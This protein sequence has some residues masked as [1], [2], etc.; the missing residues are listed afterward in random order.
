M[1]FGIDRAGEYRAW[2]TGRVALLT[3]PS[4]R[5]QDNRSSMEALREV[6]DLTLLLGPEHGVRGDKAAGESYDDAMDEET[7]LQMVSL[8]Q[9]GS[10]HLSDKAMARFDTLVYDNDTKDNLETW[11][12]LYSARGK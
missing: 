5:T 11:F 8:Y 4:G 9:A 10:R 1:R 6:C 12:H 7:G 3:T 2:L